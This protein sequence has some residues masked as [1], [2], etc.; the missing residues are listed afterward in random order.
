MAVREDTLPRR[1]F[2]PVD[3]HRVVGAGRTEPVAGVRVCR[4]NVAAGI[5]DQPNAAP[6][7]RKAEHIQVAVPAAAVH[8]YL[9]YVDYQVQVADRAAHHA[10]VSKI[11][12]GL[13]GVTLVRRSPRPQKT[14]AAEEQRHVERNFSGKCQ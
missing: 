2:A 13:G 4:V 9:A 8:S 10:A 14:V 1:R 11:P 7:Q 3:Q 12:A 5:D 6:G